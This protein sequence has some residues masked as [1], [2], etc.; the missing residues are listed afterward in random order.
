[1]TTDIVTKSSRFYCVSLTPDICKT[2]VGSGTPPLPYNVIGE[3]SEA[4]AV[5]AN[6]KARSSPVILHQRSTIPTVKGDEPGTA[7]GVKSGTVGKQVDTKSASKKH[8]ANGAD[9]VQTGREVWMNSRNT[10]GKIFERGVE[11]ARPALS[12]LAQEYKDKHSADAHE[13]G[14]YLIEKGGD[15]AGKGALT[16]AGGAALTATGVL[17]PLGIPTTAAGTAAATGGGVAMAGGA[18]LEGAATVLDQTADYVLTGESPGFLAA[19]EKYALTTGVSLAEGIALRRLGGAGTWLK[20]WLDGK[21]GPRLKKLADRKAGKK[22]SEDARKPP[23]K[24]ENEG[25][26]KGTKKDKKNDAPSD[27]CPKDKG[28]ANKSAKGR[29]PVHFG[30]G[31]EILHQTDFVIDAAIPIDWTRCY[32]SGAECEDWGPFGARWA[33]AYTTSISVT[34]GGIVYHDDSGRTLRLPWLGPSQK[35]DSRKEG[36][37]LSRS[38]NDEFTLNWLDGSVDRFTRNGINVLP[39]GYDGVNMMLPPTAPLETQRYVLVSSTGRDGRGLKIE[40]MPDPKHGEVMLRV[41]TDDGIR[42]EAIRE[43]TRAVAS[44]KGAPAPPARIGKVEQVMA[45]GKR[46]CHVTYA[47]EA[48]P[49]TTAGTDTPRQSF[50]RRYNLVR[51]TN[52]LGDTRRYT[53]Q[54]HLMTGC[55]TYTGFTQTIKWISLAALRA[56]WSGMTIDEIQL[57]ELHPIT[58][59]NSYQA[60]A[61]ATHAADDSEHVDIAYLD[62]NTTR[63][64][65]ACGALDYVFDSNWLITDVK[66]VTNGIG[67]S[68]GKREWDDDGML[69]AETTLAGTTRFSYDAAGN[70]IR[71]VDALGNKT[72]VDYNACNQPVAVADAL[73][74]VTRRSYDAAGRLASITDALGHTTKYKYDDH[75]WLV[76]LVDAKGGAKRISYDSAGRVRTYTDCSGYTTS[77]RYDEHGRLSVLADALEQE[78]HYAYDSIGRLVCLTQPDQT[79]SLFDYDADGRL[80]SQTD[81][82]GNQTLYRYNGQSL[83]VERIDANGNSLQYRYDGALQLVELINAKG[84]TYR[85]GYTPEGDLASETGF[86][87]K[88]T[89]YTYD[90]RGHLCASECAGQRIELSRDSLGRLVTKTSTDR[91]VRYTYNGLNQVTAVS[92]NHSDHS[93]AY[94]A[95]GQ[96][97]HERAT[98]SLANPPITADAGAPRIPTVDFLLTHQY[99]ELGNR[100]RTTMPD[101]CQIET[102]RYG[103]GH[104]HGLLWNGQPLVDV[105]RD[106]LHRERSRQ[107]GVGQS[108]LTAVREHDKRSRLALQQVTGGAGTN[109]ASVSERRFY[110]DSVGNL[111]RMEQARNSHG[112]VREKFLYGYDS[113]GQLL[114]STGPDSVERFSFDATGNLQNISIVHSSE[115]DLSSSTQKGKNTASTRVSDDEFLGEKFDSQ[116]NLIYKKRPPEKNGRA[117][118]IFLNYDSENNLRFS[119]TITC[120]YIYLCKYIYDAFGRRICKKTKKYILEEYSED[121]DA[122]TTDFDIETVF[123]WNGNLLL[124][125]FDDKSIVTYIHEPDNFIPLA[126]ISSRRTEQFQNKELFSKTV[127]KSAIQNNEDIGF[128][129]CDQI[130]LPRELLSP[131]SDHI[132]WQSDTTTW[133]RVKKSETS[134]QQSQPF[135]FQ[136]QYE[137]IETGLHYNCHRYYDPDTGRYVTKDPIGLL[138]GLSSYTYGA[139]PTGWIDPL[140]L[141]TSMKGCNPCCG[142]NVSAEAAATQGISPSNLTNPYTGKD[143]YTDMIVRKGTIFYSLYPGGSPGFAVLNHVLIKAAGDAKRYHDLTQVQSE[144][145]P[146]GRNMRT[147]LA[148]FV[149]LEDICVAKGRALNNSHFGVG[150]G[151]QYYISPSDTSKIKRGKVRNI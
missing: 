145:L 90:P 61:T 118:E 150:G 47:Y 17:A 151:T 125:E 63:V 23:P 69:L 58:L 46:I 96:L 133:G 124:R 13:L 36:F 4:T 136:G 77:Y 97:L 10:I 142:R 149:V 99:D 66:R 30:T 106:I 1:M 85:L 119:K 51:Q 33:S 86:D 43:N 31:Q 64:T 59:D 131:K 26:V 38:D 82:N 62:V 74:N 29:K 130:G 12:A 80:T 110:Y 20:K 70:L 14:A 83:P 137:D 11:A 129:N 138:G 5:S 6:V 144:N 55:S 121:T 60:R 84:E 3:F 2:P 113:I 73:G 146:P 21:I 109:A 140:G 95:L 126:K 108:R 40:R 88:A 52:L 44:A 111:D 92:S 115:N 35:C 22:P 81:A 16:A 45:D 25:K 19:A 147:Q 105:E 112:H 87:G 114:L 42:V 127:V 89:I 48:E 41:T 8:R 53:Y 102:L 9:L 104:W 120:D 37:A 7:R 98:Y 76:E 117:A 78:T 57:S 100:V 49:D 56:R 91:A 50:P 141:A 123:L 132:T 39:H 67:R 134:S 93:F 135:R 101:G 139:N 27:C 79:R 94:D 116:G 68:L 32:R 128:Y 122:P 15:V 103:S 148:V 65:D 18:V 28:P 107:M 71:S 143:A 24:G 75:G 34:D 54:H 72:S